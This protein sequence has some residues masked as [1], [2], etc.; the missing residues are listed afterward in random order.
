[1]ATNDF[2]YT[3]KNVHDGDTIRVVKDNK[4]YKIRLACIDAR[5][6]QQKGGIGDR[7]FLRK[8]IRDNGDRVKLNVTGKDRYK[9][10]IAEVYVK[11]GFIQEIQVKNGKA[12]SYPQYKKD[13]PNFPKIENAEQF[14]KNNKLGLWSEKNVIPP[15][16]FRKKK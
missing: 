9:R 10:L 4:E 3:V 2:D 7:D 16:E 8:L 15:S 12:F 11:Q 6:L 14:A 5:E 13:C 1:M